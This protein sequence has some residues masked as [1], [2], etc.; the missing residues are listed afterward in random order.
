MAECY[1]VS[2]KET[3][4]RTRQNHLKNFTNNVK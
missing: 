2:V 1:V 4:D 3:V